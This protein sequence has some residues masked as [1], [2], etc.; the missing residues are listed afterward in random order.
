MRGKQPKILLWDLE[1]TS[2][3]PQMGNILCFT[4]GWY[5]VKSGTCKPKIIKITDYDQSIKPVNESGI[6]P[7][8]DFGVVQDA[9]AILE[10]A[11]LL[12]RQ[13]N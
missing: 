7:T 5:N 12:A 1:T 13:G 2:F 3:D 6:N 8:D 10:E 4:Y 11:D 9:K